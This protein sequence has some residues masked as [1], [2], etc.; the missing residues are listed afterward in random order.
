M[1]CT[2][3]GKLFNIV[4]TWPGR[5]ARDAQS[6]DR[7]R[8]WKP[9]FIVGRWFEDVSRR[10][11]MFDTFGKPACLVL[12][13]NVTSKKKP[14]ETLWERLLSALGFRQLFLALGNREAPE[15]DTL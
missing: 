10:K 14:E 11:I 3:E 8:T 13:W 6:L 1:G 9:H 12:S 2:F 5:A 15:A 4:T 7:P